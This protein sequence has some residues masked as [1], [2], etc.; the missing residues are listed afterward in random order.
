LANRLERALRA[1]LEKL[2]LDLAAA[3]RR[4]AEVADVL[5]VSSG[6]D[7]DRG[8]V[9]IAAVALDHYYTSIEASL[10]MVSRVFDATSP[11][12]AD[13]HRSLLRTMRQA[14]ET[15]PPVITSETADGL[16]ELLAFR[17]FLRHAY[18]AELEWNRM[19]DLAAAL[20]ALQEKVT[21]DMATFRDYV[22]QCLGEAERCR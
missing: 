9:A 1:L 8:G 2:T 7:P 22:V 14:T 20:P 10:E 19:R 11:A 16:D 5:R 13:W 3:E 15:R 6:V 17:H 4:A 12:G 18:A 21:E